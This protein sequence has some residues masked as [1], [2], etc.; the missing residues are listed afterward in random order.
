MIPYSSIV[1]NACYILRHIIFRKS[2]TQLKMV[3]KSLKLVG[4]ENGHRTDDFL[5]VFH[6]CDRWAGLCHTCM[7]RITLYKLLHYLRCSKPP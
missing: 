3:F 7:Q 6:E 1:I 5:L 2:L 4:Y